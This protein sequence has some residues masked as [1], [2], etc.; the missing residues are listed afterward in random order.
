ML[1]VWHHLA[2]LGLF[3]LLA[4]A[5]AL[6]IAAAVIAWLMLTVHAVGPSLTGEKGTNVIV[7]EACPLGQLDIRDVESEY[8]TLLSIGDYSEEDKARL[9]RLLERYE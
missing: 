4:L 3:G 7:D 9:V 8:F 6:I 5:V 1:I 2:T